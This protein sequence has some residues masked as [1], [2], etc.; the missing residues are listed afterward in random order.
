MANDLITTLD[1]SKLIEN[2]TEEIKKE[3]A[4]LSN[5]FEVSRENIINVIEKGND[6]IN[7]FAELARQSQHPRSYE[8]LAGLMKAVLEANR[9]LLEIHKTTQKMNTNKVDEKTG[10]IITKNGNTNIIMVGSTKD[11]LK[12]IKDNNVEDIILDEEEE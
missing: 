8:V 6:A 2:K 11:V 7:T 4:I 1:V 9:A 10:D 5:D 3:V 12:L